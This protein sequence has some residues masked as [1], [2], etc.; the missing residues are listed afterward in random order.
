MYLHVS[1]AG[2]YREELETGVRVLH[3]R[4]MQISRVFPLNFVENINTSCNLQISRN[5][6]TRRKFQAVARRAEDRFVRQKH[7]H[8]LPV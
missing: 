7:E 1:K 2:G 5:F 4:M 6:N 8:R 3:K